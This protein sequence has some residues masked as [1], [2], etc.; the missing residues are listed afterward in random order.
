MATATIEPVTNGTSTPPA[1]DDNSLMSSGT[2]RKRTDN[3]DAPQTDG[4]FDSIVEESAAVEGSPLVQE[5]L[6]DILTVLRK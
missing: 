5:S 1:A 3:E 2:K 4:L 6:K